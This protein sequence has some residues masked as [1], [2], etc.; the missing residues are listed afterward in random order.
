MT[1]LHIAIV[2]DEEL[3]RVALRRFCSALGMRVSIYASG[4]ALIDDLDGSAS[5]VDCLLLD[6]H[7]PDMTGLEILQQLVRRAVR[8]PTIVYS[9]DDEPEAIDRYIEAGAVAYLRKP[10]LADALINAI[11]R[12]VDGAS[13]VEG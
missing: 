10:V 12:A 2:D 13:A 11:T 9:A 7:M 6:A 3:I 4:R 8:F 1:E 5:A